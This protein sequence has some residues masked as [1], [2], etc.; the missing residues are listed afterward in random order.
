VKFLVI[1]AEKSRRIWLLGRFFDAAYALAPH[2][3]GLSGLMRGRFRFIG[4]Q[5]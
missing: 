1:T 5:E 4:E 3:Q 2:K